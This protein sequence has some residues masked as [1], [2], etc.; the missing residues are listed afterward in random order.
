MASSDIFDYV[1]VG[2]G[3]AG[4]LLASRLAQN[5]SLRICLLE[6]GPKDTNPFIH[7]PAGFI[8]LIFNP[9]ITWGFNTEPGAH[10]NNR[11]VPVLQGKVVGGSSSI[12][13]MIY[14][15]GQS[16][17]YDTWGDAGIKGWSYHD[18]LPYFKRTEA[19]VTDGDHKYRGQTGK[20]PVTHLT[21]KNNLVSAFIEAAQQA[22]IPR[23]DG[24][25]GATQE[26]VGVYQSNIGRGFRKGTAQAFLKEAL[27]KGTINLRTKAV[28]TELIFDERG[29]SGV[30]YTTDQGNTHQS[31]YASK[32][33]ILCC[34]AINTPRLMQVSGIGDAEHLDSISVPLKLHLPGVGQNLRDHYTARFTSKVS[35]SQTINDIVNS[36][37]K[38]LWEGMK[39]LSGTPSILGMGVVLAGA[40]CKSEPHLDRPDLVITFTPGSFKEGFLGVLDNIPGMT[41]GVWP[42]RPFSSGYVKAKSRNVFEAPAIQPNYLADPRDRELLLKG[43]KIVRDIL[44]KPAINQYIDQELMP[45][46]LIKSDEEL[47]EYGRIQGLGGYHYCG[48]CRMGM[49]NDKL[50]V[51]D[52][53]LNVHGISGLRIVDASVMPNIVSGNTN[54]AT[55][56]IAERGAEFVL[57]DFA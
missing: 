36:K 1:I 48:T 37:P 32:Q 35:G 8:K 55:M 6:A 51:V 40:F 18:V 15:R 52:S 29:V 7:I 16:Q 57:K 13:G 5:S 47:D 25:N 46:S 14:V 39:W 21:W 19:L 30:K 27:K 34:G 49:A 45:G 41:T 20:M 38:L 28:A 17:D 24:Y 50:A 2:A 23:N 11:S 53:T 33:V 12:N 10:I 42:L 31:V 56:M 54:A 43:Q 4:S 9:N 3:S 22:N 44:G 26:G